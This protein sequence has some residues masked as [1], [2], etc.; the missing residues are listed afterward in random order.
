MSCAT[1]LL[2]SHNFTTL[3]DVIL[4]EKGTKFLFE[5][6]LYLSKSLLSTI[7]YDLTNDENGDSW[8]LQSSSSR[9]TQNPGQLSRNQSA[10]TRFARLILFFPIEIPIAE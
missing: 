3:Y 7:L 6:G 1:W 4:L 10:H 5:T 9:K 8:P 2:F